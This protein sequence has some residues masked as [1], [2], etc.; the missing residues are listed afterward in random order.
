M[1]LM[2][3]GWMAVAALFFNSSPALAVGPT[4]HTATVLETMN[5]GGYTY[6]KVDEDGKVF[7]AAAPAAQ[8]KVGDQVNFTEQMKKVNF[9]SPSLNRTFDELM[10]VS[11]L[12]G[13]SAARGAPAS[14]STTAAVS[15]PIAKVEGGYTVEEIFAQKEALK[16]KPIKVRGKVVKVSKNIMGLNWIHIQDGTG[17]EGAD[18]LIFR[19]KTGVV[20]VGSVVTAEGTLDTDKDFG[21]GYKYS[22]LVEN[23]TFAE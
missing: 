8:V 3:A 13:G 21:Y 22:V 7:W 4:V 23:A 14:S 12:G 19:S 1:H 2:L 10:F 11:G 20:D 18:R 15:E 6:L 5:S 9:T 16:G 17:A